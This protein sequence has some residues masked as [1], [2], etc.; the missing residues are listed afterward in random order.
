VHD[1]QVYVASGGLDPILRADALLQVL[2]YGN[3]SRR[4]NEAEPL[5]TY[6]VGQRRNGLRVV[7]DIRGRG[8]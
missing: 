4:A 5:M 8:V 7:A 2:D 6:D 3:Q 1:V